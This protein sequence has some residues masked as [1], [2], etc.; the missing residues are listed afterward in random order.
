[1][2]NLRLSGHRRWQLVKQ[3]A[4]TCSLQDG[5]CACM[6]CTYKETVDLDSKGLNLPVFMI[7]QRLLF[8]LCNVYSTHWH[9]MHRRDTKMRLWEK[10]RFSCRRPDRQ[11]LV[12]LIA[13]CYLGQQFFVQCKHTHDP[14]TVSIRR[15]PVYTQIKEVPIFRVWPDL[16][17][18]LILHLDLHTSTSRSRVHS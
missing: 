3:W 15:F 6:Q 16:N 1:M 7:F 11:P 8:S 10:P 12:S 9:Y 17:L 5:S 2:C 13:L 18:Y 4:P 14:P